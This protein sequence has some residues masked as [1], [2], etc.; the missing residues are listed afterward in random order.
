MSKIVPVLPIDEY[1]QA[2]DFYVTGLG[3]SILFEH[4][5]EPGF[6]VHMGIQHGEMLLHLS[7]HAK[8]HRGSELYLFVED[9]SVWHER[10]LAQDIAIEEPPTKRVWGNTEMLLKDPF[11]NA[12][13]VTQ[14]N[15]H[16]AHGPSN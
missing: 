10:C 4:R 5:H 12:I 13:R 16:P 2:V 9:L 7:E 15:T 11:G 8:G 14:E 6:P 3:F 1:Q